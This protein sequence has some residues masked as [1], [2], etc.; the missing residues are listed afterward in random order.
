MP[1]KYD[2]ID[3]TPPEGVREAAKQGLEYRREYGRGGTDVG[4][5][6]ARDLANGRDM[7]PETI[8]RMSSFFARHEEN[9]DAD[10]REPDGGPTNGWIAWLLWGGDAGRAWASKV[11]RQ[12]DAA[13]AAV[14]GTITAEL[15]LRQGGPER[16]TWVRALLGRTIHREMQ[17]QPPWPGSPELLR[18]IAAETRRWMANLARYAEESGADTPY[19]PP[20]YVS[21]DGTH[22]RR[23]DILDVKVAPVDDGDLMALFVKVRWNSDTWQ[24][25]EARRW[26][27]VSVGVKPMADSHGESYGPVLAELSLTEE[28]LVED[29]G[30]IQDTITLT[31]SRGVEIT[32]EVTPTERDQMEEIM[33]ELVGQ[34][35]AIMAKLDE[36]S[37]KMDEMSAMKDEDEMSAEMDE[38]K[39]EMSA[40]REAVEAMRDVVTILSASQAAAPVEVPE[41]NTEE[42][43]TQ[44]APPSAAPRTDAEM[45]QAAREQGLKGAAAA[46][47]ILEQRKR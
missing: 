43:P 47:W 39:D 32:A 19:T 18:E 9:R 26:T 35:A 22:G 8:R 40:M 15:V 5:A 1:A 45:I 24:E 38:D 33:Q 11:S 4:I 44:A 27:G 31:L 7:S 25:I 23:G 6:R 10:E 36:M 30:T 12:M 41:Q 42:P 46:R 28:P 29:L 13:D 20:I 17:G 14:T 3:F 34:M 16:V 21:H 2:H 37:A